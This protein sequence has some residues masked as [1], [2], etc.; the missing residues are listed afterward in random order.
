M[1]LPGRL[2]ALCLAFVFALTA[3]VYAEQASRWTQFRGPSV[4]GPAVGGNLPDGTFGLRVEWTRDL[5]SGY[6]HVW[7]TDGKAVTM[8]TAGEVDVVAAFDLASGEE[9]WRYELGEKYA[10]HDGSQDGP[11]GTPTVSEDVVYALGPW[12][13]LVA[14]SMVDGTEKW[15][16]QLD[17]SD[18]T[19][20][21]YGYTSSPVVT[22][23]RV[24]V[25]TGGEG[26]AVTAFDRETGEPVWAAGDGIVSYQT[27][28]LVEL[29]G[30]EQLIALTNRDLMGIDPADGGIIWELQHTEG[31]EGDETAHP[32]VLDDE[33]FLVAYQR[34]ARLYRWTG[35]GVEE[36]W[37]TRAFGNTLALPVLIG[38]HFYG[39]SG[40]VLTCVD[41]ETG[42]IVWRTREL[43]GLG[44]SAVDGRLAVLSND[45]ELVVVDASPGGYREVT[46]HKVLEN[47]N[48]PVPSFADGLFVVRNLQQMAAVKVDASLAPQTALADQADRLKGEFGQWIASIE[49]LPESERQTAVDQ[50]FATVETTPLVDDGGLAHLVWRGEAEDVGVRGD[51]VGDGQELGL[52]RVGGTDLF[53]RSLELDPKAQYTY[54]FLVD[55]GDPQLDPRNPYSVDF[56]FFQLSELRMPDW[57]AAP[58]LDVPAD[59]APRGTLDRFPF[60]SDILDNTREIRVWRPADYGRD[61][62]RRYPVLVVNH[63]DNVLRGGLMQNALDNLV[64]KSVAPLIAV[65]VPRA[66]GPEYGGPSAE[67][68]MRFLLEELLPH[69]D[70]HY[71]TDPADRA[72]MGPG[73]AGV[74]AVLAAFAHPEVFRRAAVQS[75]YPIEPTHERLPGMIAAEGEK[76]ELVYVV[77]S[78]HDYDLGE[79]RTAADATEELLGWLRASEIDVVEQIAD[80]SPG[81]GGWRGQYDE[82][83]AALFPLAPGK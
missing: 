82:I 69:L 26:H 21:T 34:G 24:I 8:F 77:W 53:F 10:G 41:G 46:R 30:R 3:P 66:A 18:S 2:S 38:D 22:G 7:T 15:R 37:Q 57:P 60:R 14:L 72:I 13:Q 19:V 76:P 4:E 71:L 20:P 75:F 61:P 83:L 28:M 54:G 63:G 44:L 1:N 64:G 65:F 59:D 42:E 55:F 45:G 74:A 58:H 9:L 36:V 48:Y 43:S 32:T 25:A 51:F 17:E 29:G 6:S 70:H 49:A 27:P 40:T 31:R 35:N 73:S 33:R 47:G 11:L 12:G 81:W 68:Y 78:R 16:R 62:E 23:K 56:G 80:Y 5:G 52:H 67:D 50:R 79:G 39:F